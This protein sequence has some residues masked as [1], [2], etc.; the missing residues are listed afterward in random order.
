MRTSID[1]RGVASQAS[2]AAE[3]RS[4]HIKTVA[5]SAAEECWEHFWL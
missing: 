4:V 2:G 3:R 5:E 1:L